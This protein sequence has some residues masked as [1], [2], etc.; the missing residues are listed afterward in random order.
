MDDVL[1]LNNL[2]ILSLVIMFIFEITYTTDTT[3]YAL[4]LDLQL[5]IDSEAQLR[6]KRYDKTDY[7]N[8]R[9]HLDSPP[10]FRWV[11]VDHSFCFCV[12]FLYIFLFFG[13]SSCLSV[14][15]LFILE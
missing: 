4:H 9:E 2:I 3:R 7:F 5:E 12:V 6:A 11:R 10:V 15:R 8:F 14:S 1:S 13:L